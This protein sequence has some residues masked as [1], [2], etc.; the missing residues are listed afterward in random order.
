MSQTLQSYRNFW[1]EYTRLGDII[2]LLHWDSE[3][4][5]PDDAREERAEQIAQLSS[6]SHKMF[7]G[8]EAKQHL[9]NLEALI[10]SNPPEKTIL[11]REMEVFKKDRDRAVTL[12]IELVER[13]SKLTNLAHG[14]WADAK[15]NKDF[16]AFE[17]TLTEITELSIEMAECYGYTTERYDALLEGYETGARAKDLEELFLHLKNS[18]IPIVNE[19]KSYSSPFKKPIPVELQK[20]FNEKLPAL[21]GLPASASRLDISVHPFS[22]SLGSKDKRITT[23]Y[24][25]DDPLSSIFGVLH[26]TGHALYEY[27]VGQMANYPSPLTS[28][29]SLGVHESQSRLWENQVGRSRAFWEYYY[30]ILLKEFN[31][32]HYDLP[33][34]DFYNYV[35][36]VN[37]SKIRVEADQVTY[38]LHI[39]LRFEI[40]R[41][42]ISRKIKVSDL[43]EVWNTKMKESFDLKIEND[44]EGVLQDVHW[45]G[46]AFGYF[47]TYTLGNI[48]SAQLFHH[49]LA[50]HESFWDDLLKRGDVSSLNKWLS[51]KVYSHGR[52]LDPKDLIKEVTG[53]LPKSDYLVK[54]LKSKVQEQE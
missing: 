47:P 4:M 37:K 51:K 39:I 46:G 49:F 3:V 44:G 12:P 18:L 28:A 45:S 33:F 16:K 38:N 32:Y 40:E 9:E 43:P 22:T 36:S 29:V 7:T 14:I 26:E 53:E 21:L 5:M 2:S 54:Y 48:Y 31:I 19:G 8:D 41:D 23:R 17:P 1:K 27:G 50:T 35:N 52:I 34:N 24:H 25:V 10:A 13:F 30:P 11:K 6:L 42:L 15:K 20:S